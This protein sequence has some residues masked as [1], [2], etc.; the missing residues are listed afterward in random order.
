MSYY[1]TTSDAAS[2]QLFLQKLE[3]QP[4]A[5]Y[6]MLKFVNT[7]P[8]MTPEQTMKALNGG[9]NISGEFPSAICERIPA[10]L[11]RPPANQG[12]V[13]KAYVFAME[14]PLVAS[15]L[16][17]G[18]LSGLLDSAPQAQFLFNDVYVNDWGLEENI[19]YNAQA[20]RLGGN[21]T[22]DLAKRYGPRLKNA[23]AWNEASYSIL[24]AL[25]EGY[26]A[27]NILSSSS[28]A[29]AAYTDGGTLGLTPQD[30]VNF[31]VPGLPAGTGDGYRF[32]TWNATPATYRSALAKNITRIDVDEQFKPSYGMLEILYEEASRLLQWHKNIDGQPLFTM[33]IPRQIFAHLI[34]DAGFREAAMLM[35]TGSD[36]SDIGEVIRR[37][38][39]LQVS[40]F[41]I[42]VLDHVGLQVFTNYAGQG[43]TLATANGPGDTITQSNAD[44]IYYGYRNNDFTPRLLCD[45]SVNASAT[46][47][48]GTKPWLS[49][50][51]GA[52]FTNGALKSL[53]A[54][55]PH[56]ER[57]FRN[58]NTKKTGA[59]IGCDGW[60]RN[61][62]Y[63]YLAGSVDTPAEASACYNYSSML[64]GCYAPPV[65]VLN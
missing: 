64:F 46:S 2:V 47:D 28:M 52:I 5:Q 1:M 36:K 9:L 45:P 51:C 62:W 20:T 6:G 14:T 24:G 7:K 29:G 56:I 17:T 58:Y 35:A 54:T 12:P 44:T 27:R 22:L 63:A 48:D 33:V 60:R 19:E 50:W 43:Y 4:T 25:Y 8:E 37:G 30:H 11:A 34:R 49:R 18:P 53:Q 55:V 26:S 31:C 16:K 57:E 40:G 38:K 39:P 42:H 3:Q 41:E 61:D 23:M 10:S 32:A 21:W 59:I 65:N 15:S 13:N